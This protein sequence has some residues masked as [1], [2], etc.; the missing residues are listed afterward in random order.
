MNPSVT[1]NT[2]NQF[3]GDSGGS[4]VLTDDVSLKVFMDHLI[5]L[6]VQS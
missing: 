4:V 6:S 3:G 2:S 1:H 5:R